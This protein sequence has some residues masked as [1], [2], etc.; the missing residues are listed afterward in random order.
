MLSRSGAVTSFSAALTRGENRAEQP[1]AA[2]QN[3]ERWVMI[4]SKLENF[5]DRSDPYTEE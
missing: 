3:R 2:A 1:K 5:R 4:K